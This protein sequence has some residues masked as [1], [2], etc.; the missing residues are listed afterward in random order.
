MHLGYEGYEKYYDP[1]AGPGKFYR[2]NLHTHTTRSDGKLKPKE[3]FLY[4]FVM[5]YDF[6]A[7]SDHRVWTDMPEIGFPGRFITIPAAEISIYGGGEYA[8]HEGPNGACA[9]IS[10]FALD[11]SN[12]D[13]PKQDERLDNIR[14]DLPGTFGQAVSHNIKL[15]RDRGCM[16]CVNHP[17]WSRS[18]DDELLDMDGMFAT[19]VF[20]A[21]SHL[22]HSA[23]GE[24]AFDYCL[25][26][27]KRIYGIAADDNHFADSAPSVGAVMVKAPELTREA[28]SKALY[29]G[30]FYST[31]G[32]EIYEFKLIRR[33][34]YIKCSPASKIR[35]ITYEPLGRT[36]EGS[37]MTE[38]NYVL[39][40]REKYVR[41]EVCDENGRKAWTN[42][43]FLHGEDVK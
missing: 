42:P 13:L 18:F 34:V 21:G 25:R 10:A 41:V 31:Q 29:E 9:H 3:A 6:M 35:F 33:T 17:D 39:S 24:Y 27:G 40:G 8:S 26:N 23:S 37:A 32:P 12:P 22:S 1:F 38:G 11:Y 20:N 2:G 36:F 16:V 43:I 28:I 30:R 7:I 14:A 15:L 5:G 4:Y 19:E